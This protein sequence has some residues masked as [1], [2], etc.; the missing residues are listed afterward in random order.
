MGV[1]NGYI[2]VRYAIMKDVLMLKMSK[3]KTKTNMITPIESLL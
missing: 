1:D 3:E 2:I